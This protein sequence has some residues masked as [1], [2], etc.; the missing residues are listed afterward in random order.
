MNVIEIVDHLPTFWPDTHVVDLDG[1]KMRTLRS[2]YLRIARALIF[3]DYF[4]KNLDALA[5]CLGS[6]EHVGSQNVVLFIRHFDDFLHKE[7]SE[8]RQAALQVLRDAQDPKHR[9]DTV[10]LRVMGM[11]EKLASTI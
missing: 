6:L 4:G 7:K 8:K 10:K 3:P 5:D 2:F 9:Y 11:R 1:S